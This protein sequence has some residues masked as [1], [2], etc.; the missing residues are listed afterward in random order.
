[1]DIILLHLK[2]RSPFID[3]PRLPNYCMV[4][5]QLWLSY[6]TSGALGWEC[7]FIELGGG[8]PAIFSAPGLRRG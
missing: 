5:L 1:M 8:Y 3:H 7:R 6:M 2:G 4:T